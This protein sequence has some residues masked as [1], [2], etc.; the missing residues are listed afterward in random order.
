MAAKHKVSV[1]VRPPTARAST[2]ERR[3]AQVA[4][5][6]TEQTNLKAEAAE[7]RANAAPN[8]VAPVAPK[9]RMSSARPGSR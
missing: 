9:P 5:L 2:A 4:A 1:S 3:A 7:R 8:K 6:A